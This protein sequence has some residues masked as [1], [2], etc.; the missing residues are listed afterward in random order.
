VL[1]DPVQA[2]VVGKILRVEDRGANVNV[3]I[4]DGTGELEI[5]H[6]LQEEAEYV[7][8]SSSSSSSTVHQDS[9]S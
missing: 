6:W 5:S 3:F 2:T 1:P 9:T 4:T 7:S 8:S